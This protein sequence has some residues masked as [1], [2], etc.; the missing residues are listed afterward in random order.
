MLGDYLKDLPWLAILFQNHT[1]TL[2]KNMLAQTSII[3][4]ELAANM[5]TIN[6]VL[7]HES[8]TA[9][10]SNSKRLLPKELFF[11]LK[12]PIARLKNIKFHLGSWIDT[13][14]STR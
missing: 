6:K 3:M 7:A 10:T 1:G 2:G 11:K 8:G 9:D 4:Q 14:T 5:E 12:N 13:I